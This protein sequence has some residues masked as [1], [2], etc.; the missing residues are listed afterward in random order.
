MATIKAFIIVAL[1]FGVFMLGPAMV[2]FAGIAFAIWFVR[3]LLLE[4]KKA[5]KDGDDHGRFY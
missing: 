5:K 4:D 1:V 2:T 3:E